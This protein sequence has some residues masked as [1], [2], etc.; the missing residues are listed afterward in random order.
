MENQIQEDKDFDSVADKVLDEMGTKTP[1]DSSSADKQKDEQTDTADTSG[2]EP[3][4]TEQVKAVE[5]D[6]SLSVEQKIAKIKDIL[7][8]DENALNAYIQTKGYHNDP[9]WIKQRE[10]IEKL[11]KE[12]A[13]K[14]AFS[15]EDR[16]AFDEFTAFRS[17]PEYT[18]MIMKQ[19]GY[20]QDAIDK[21][22]Q[23][24]GHEVKPNPQDDVNLVLEKLGIDLNKLSP[25]S[26]ENVLAN[27][28]DIIKIADILI[29]DRFGKVLPKELAPIQEDLKIVNQ[30]KAGI[31]LVDTMKNIVKTDDILDFDKDVQPVLNKFLDENPDANQQDVFEY[32][33]SINHN[34]TI[35]RLKT[36]KKKDER[37][38]KK[39]FIRQNLSISRSSQTPKKTGHFNNDAD[40]FLDSVNYEK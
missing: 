38:E 4:K 7:G 30:E 31:K 18:Q 9:A 22:L 20:T 23:E 28:E 6:S 11:K 3:V 15:D 35:E 25:E 40:S 33:K 26:K 17:S 19:Q 16:K 29:Q 14:P 34:L 24:S 8:D 36:G 12:N 13:A 27:V 1:A 32:F 5:S 37:D 2:A 39:G 10:I 21:K